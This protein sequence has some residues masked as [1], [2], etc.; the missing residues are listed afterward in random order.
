MSRILAGLDNT[1]VAKLRRLVRQ[2]V[3]EQLSALALTGITLDFDGSVL[4][5]GRFVEGTAVGFNGKMKG[6]RSN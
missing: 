4:S 6:Q 3:L 1:V 2:R 5:S